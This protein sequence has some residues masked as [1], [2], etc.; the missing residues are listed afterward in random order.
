MT[1]NTFFN[2]ETKIEIKPTKTKGIKVKKILPNYQMV[3]PV[4][5]SQT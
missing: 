5:Q 3:I 1:N 2:N 4:L